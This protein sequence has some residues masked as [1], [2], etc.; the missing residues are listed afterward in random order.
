MSK[1]IINGDTGLLNGNQDTNDI[2][3]NFGNDDMVDIN[4][5]DNNNFGDMENNNELFDNNN[6]TMLLEN[7]MERRFAKINYKTFDVR[8][9]KSKMWDSISQVIL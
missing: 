6:N 4:N 7:E 1:E 3:N 8:Y 5:N 2:N 9:I